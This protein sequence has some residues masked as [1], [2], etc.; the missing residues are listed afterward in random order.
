MNIV[1]RFALISMGVGVALGIF[2]VFTMD[3]TKGPAPAGYYFVGIILMALG[4]LL[5]K[6]EN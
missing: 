4:T 5:L 1:N 2:S 6:K 3:Y